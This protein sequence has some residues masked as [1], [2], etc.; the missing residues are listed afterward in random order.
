MYDAGGALCAEPESLTAEDASVRGAPYVP[1]T[2][3][4]ARLPHAWLTS[5]GMRPDAQTT[6]AADC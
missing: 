1:S 4:G 2:V 5:A 3:P 6:T